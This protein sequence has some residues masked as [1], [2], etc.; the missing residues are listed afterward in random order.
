MEA[1]KYIK[2]TINRFFLFLFKFFWFFG[3]GAGIVSCYTLL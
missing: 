1:F 3:G 2:Q